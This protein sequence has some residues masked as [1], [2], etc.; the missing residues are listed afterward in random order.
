MPFVPHCRV[1]SIVAPK[2]SSSWRLAI[3]TTSSPVRQI[4]ECSRQSGGTR[5]HTSSIL[6]WHPQV[7]V[8]VPR[9]QI[10]VGPQ[11]RPPLR[12]TLSTSPGAREVQLETPHEV[13]KM[14]LAQKGRR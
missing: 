3:S 5:T 14:S 2:Y 4:Q 10:R 7:H 12:A 11:V 13:D 6:R 8:F 9:C 1:S